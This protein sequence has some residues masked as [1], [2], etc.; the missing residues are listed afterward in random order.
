MKNRFQIITVYNDNT[1]KS[2]HVSEIQSA[3][4]AVSI[5]WMDPDC[6]MIRIYDCEKNINVLDYI[7][8]N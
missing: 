7:R 6:E 1:S 8:P 5:Y 4:T 3:L 2:E